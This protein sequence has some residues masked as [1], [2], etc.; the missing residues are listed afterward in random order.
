MSG[1]DGFSPLHYSL[2]KPE[3]CRWMI[4]HGADVATVD[5]NGV[6][7]FMKA[8][9]MAASTDLN[10]LGEL[11]GLV[12]PEHLVLPAPRQTPMWAAPTVVIQLQLIKHGVPVDVADPQAQG[13]LFG[14]G[15]GS[16]ESQRNLLQG[17]IEGKLA[18]FDQTFF[19]IF[20]GCARSPPS[21]PRTPHSTL[22]TSHSAP[23]LECTTPSTLVG[24]ACCP[25]KRSSCVLSSAGSKPPRVCP[26]VD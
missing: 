8:V 24:A 19:G 9:K 2:A 6:T 11:I 17:V 23:P 20:L 22:C 10:F 14:R 4:K 12:P 18:K 13:S 3:Q 21:R 16:S 1:R 26:L 5:K 25:C 15:R 7:F